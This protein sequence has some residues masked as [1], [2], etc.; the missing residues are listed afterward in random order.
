MSRYNEMNIQHFA[1]LVQEIN[2]SKYTQEEYR[3]IVEEIY[4]A[5][6]R[7][8]TNGEYVIE[9]MP[10]EEGNWKVY[11]PKQTQEEALALIK[12]RNKHGGN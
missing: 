3:D 9:T 7:H 10:N 11:K 12:E 8:N 4:M 6:F 1:N 5:I 2:V